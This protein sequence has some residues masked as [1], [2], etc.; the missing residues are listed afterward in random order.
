MGPK[1]GNTNALKHGLYARRYSIQEIK[2]LRNMSPDDLRHEIYML[3][4]IIAKFFEIISAPAS[5]LSTEAGITLTY[6]LESAVTSLNQCARTHALLNGTYAPVTE[7]LAEA[8]AN[9]PLY[10]DELAD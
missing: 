6:A 10:D 3:R 4:V 8:L 5:N 1:K 7:A 9:F 2:E